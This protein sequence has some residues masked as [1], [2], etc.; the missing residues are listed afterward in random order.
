MKQQNYDVI[1]VGAGIGGLYLADLLNTSGLKI[2]LI[3][4]RDTI[5]SL[6][7][8]YFGTFQE[9]VERHGLQKYVLYKCGWGMY[10]TE[11][12]YFNN[13]KGRTL[14]ILE[15]N[16]WAESLKL[17]CDI[18]LN[19]EII[20]IRK[21]NDDSMSVIDQ[22]YK[23]YN[24]KIIVDASGIAQAISRHLGIKPSKTDFLNYVYILKNHSLKNKSEMFYFQDSN[25]TNC[26]GWFHTLEDGKCLV[27]CAE[28]TVP[29]SLGPKELKKRLDIYIKTFN[30]LN[31]YLK[32]AELVE[33]F[34]MAGP[35]TTAHKSVVENNYL[36]IGDAAGAGGPFIGDG[37]RMALAMAESAHDTIKLAFDKN[38]FSAKTMLLHSENY[39]KEFT[40]WY[41]WSY[42]FRFIYI[43][44]L[45]NHE[46]NLLIPRLKKLPDDDYYNILRSKFTPLILW[47]IFSL[48]LACNI[49]KNMFIYYILEPLK[50]TKLAK[51]PDKL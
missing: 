43:R 11:D 44:Y 30:P 36:S 9:D 10:S 31:K 33:E 1:I 21:K 42:L 32:K 41:K 8:N 13:L 7:K 23:E 47:R 28:Y 17:N 22:N 29:K 37:F 35:T 15:M 20:A 48:R 51:R 25:L 40:K 14:Q 24:A 2:L 6:T 46:F 5:K 50:I 4:K 12:K 3:E 38:D 16:A 26:G 34:C 18:K 39:Y 49:I 27:G 45:T 19:T